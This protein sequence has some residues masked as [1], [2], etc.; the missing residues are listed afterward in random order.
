[1]N[2]SEL[3]VRRPITISVCVIAVLILGVLSFNSLGLDLFPDLQFPYVTIATVYPAA[4]PQTVEEEIT[5]PVEDIVSTLSG[6]RHVQSTSMEN[7]SLVTAEFGWGTEMSQ[8]LEDVRANLTALSLLLPDDALQPLVTS[9]DL[10][11]L[12]VMIV[13]LTSEA[14][15]EYSTEQALATVRPLFE[16]IPGVAQ[17][18]VLGGTQREIQV[19]YDSAKLEE[20]NLTPAMLEQLLSLQNALVP[21]GIIESNGTRFHARIGNHFAD[22]QEIRDLVIGES[23]L[24]VQGI[25]ALWPPL[26]HVKDVADV[27]D[28]LKTA[29]GSSRIGNEETILLQVFKRPD[30]NTVKVAQGLKQVMATLQTTAPDL[31][32]VAITDQ[33]V[34]IVSSINN[35]VLFGSFGALLAIAVL[36]LFLRNWRSILIIATAIP[37]SIV[38]T[39]AFLYFTDMSL[40]LMTLGGLSLGIGML[41]DNAI[42]VLES[43]FRHRSEGAQPEQA[44]IAGSR[45]VSGAVIAA[46]ATTIVVFL[47]VLFMET[48]AAR[49]F[50]ELGLTVSLSLF[51]SL[52]VSLTVVPAMAGT[53]LRRRIRGGSGVAEADDTVVESP[54]QAEAAVAA[55]MGEQPLAGLLGDAYERALAWILDR[56]AVLLVP[57][58]VVIGLS[59]LLWPKLGLQFLPDSASRALYVS[60]ETAPG[61][62]FA[63]TEAVADEAE[64]RLRALDL[65]EF[66]TV[67]VGEQH[68][69]DLDLLSIL[70]NHQP[71]SIKLIAVSKEAIHAAE[72]HELMESTRNMLSDLPVEY[73]SVG[74]QWESDANVFSSDIVL[75]IRG[76]DLADLEN[77]ALQLSE[78]LEGTPAI[79]EVHAGL[80]DQQ[81]EMYLAV[82]QS[83]ALI[84]GLTTAQISLSVRHA[85]TGVQATQ[86]RQNG[87]TIPVVMRPHPDELAGLDDLLNYRVSSPIPTGMDDGS[88]RLGNVVEA[89]QTTG[90]QTIRHIDGARAM[91]VRIR[92]AHT[93][94]RAVNSVLARVLDEITLPVGVTIHQSG[95]TEL[96]D[97]S[98]SELTLALL[99]ALVLVY[100]VMVAQFE[101]WSHPLIILT[102]TPLAAIGVLWALW[103]TGT[104]LSVMPLLGLIIL[105][106]IVV[107]NGILLVDY[108][109]H[110]HRDGLDVRRAVMAGARTRLRP[111]LMTAA[112]T[113][114]GMIPLAI[115]QGEGMEMQA[116]LAITVIGGLLSATV[117]TLFVI[118]TLYALLY[119]RRPRTP[120]T[121]SAGR[122]VSV[123]VLLVVTLLGGMVMGFAGLAQ[124]QTATDIGS[125][126]SSPTFVA[127]LGYDHSIDGAS[128]LLGTGWGGHTGDI[129]W[130]MYL[131]AAGSNIEQT[132]LMLGARG[133]WFQ[134]ITFAGYYELD[135]DVSLRRRGADKLLSSLSLTADAVLGNITARV[136]YDHVDE[137]FPQLPWDVPGRLEP[138]PGNPGQYHLRGQLRHQPHRELNLVREFQWA[139]RSDEHESPGSLLILTGAET[140]AGRGWLIGKVGIVVRDA[141]WEPALEAGIRLR[142]GAY[143]ELQLSVSSA[144]ALSTTPVL[145]ATYD[146]IGENRSFNARL[147]IQADADAKLQPSLFL[148]SEPH[149]GGFRWQLALD[150]GWTTQTTSFG[151]FTLF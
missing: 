21:A 142:P 73:V 1:M 96:V 82:D 43:I 36:F 48:F 29:N 16:Q 12:P 150:T 84:G 90:P 11:Q 7:M 91:E 113:I 147:S 89:R 76:N 95:V 77:V 106:G 33:S 25:A 61:T 37:L 115:S 101:S 105:G 27:V 151:I 19:L 108:I 68:Q 2:L 130:T 32:L 20:H 118:P 65:F 41:V 9:I 111:V 31:K 58:L 98:V 75:Q 120:R 45:E 30:A 46:T 59:V 127:G 47:P 103:L 102:T 64:A 140:R 53:L 56:K 15:L 86:V 5:R 71:N 69:E 60:M 38:G 135:G 34:Q 144:T 10:A 26:L 52:L 146:L 80:S 122:T 132:M 44:A 40:N 62:P 124:A 49:L 28:G 57:V 39:I 50:K 112:T 116:P 109:N 22:V 131:A 141:S 136:E 79:A 13:G 123:S 139:R 126:G 51:A 100:L 110:L 35:L 74:G 24:P 14:G 81:P 63:Q 85:L 137:N 42:I 99:F 149:R 66:I 8:T 145:N 138:L 88:I 143:S 107:N 70:S 54:A 83:R 121:S 18:A 67:Q 134:P 87:R 3:A 128:F 119:E 133:H 148:Q 97:E 104:H 6:L 125:Q 72:H 17:V 114:G 117:L 55:E 129:D 92:P 93:D 23:R 4:D 78:R 94:L